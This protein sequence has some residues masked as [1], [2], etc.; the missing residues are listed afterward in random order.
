VIT[1]GTIVLVT[2]I[3]VTHTIVVIAILGMI[4]TLE[5][6]VDT[7]MRAIINVIAMMTGIVI[8]LVASD[9]AHPDVV[10]TNAG[11]PRLLD[12]ISRM[13][14]WKWMIEDMMIVL[15]M[16]MAAMKTAED[17]T[18]I[19]H[20]LQRGGTTLGLKRRT[21][22]VGNYWSIPSLKVN[23]IRRWDPNGKKKDI[24]SE[25]T[26]LIGCSLSFAYY[27]VLS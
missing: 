17:V 5:E 24:G 2:V 14:K 12:E 16:K 18:M 19:E 7:G 11:A 3:G 23:G 21:V 26:L 4:D 9:L 27:L 20:H 1:E 6:T 8:R 25:C 13:E 22:V 10:V 15:A